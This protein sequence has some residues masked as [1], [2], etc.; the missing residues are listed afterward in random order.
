MNEVLCNRPCSFR[1][2]VFCKKEY[3]MIN[4]LGQCEEWWSKQGQPY[5]QQFTQSN[6]AENVTN[7]N[8]TPEEPSEKNIENS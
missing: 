1:N 6:P 8:K 7:D 2:G 4:Q 3:V 5:Y